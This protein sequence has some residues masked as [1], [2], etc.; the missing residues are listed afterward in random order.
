MNKLILNTGVQDFIKENLNTDI[1][2]VL[3]KKLLFN[4]IAQKELAQQLESRKR[5]QEKLPTWFN[6]DG[7][8]YP[9]K[10]HLEQT[11]SEIT[12]HYKSRLVNGNTLLDLT[13]GLGVDSYF[14]SKKM[15]WVTHCEMNA[16][17]SE[18][19]IYNFKVL[20][21]E[22]IEGVTE[23]G[24]DYLAEKPREWDWIFI[25]PS[26]RN[27]EKGK[28]FRL[29][30]CLPNVP[31][32]LPLI[33]QKTKNVLIKTSPLL[34]IAQGISELQ[35]VKE[36][37]AVA[38]KNE[39]KELLF[40]LEKDFS[41]EIEI[42]TIDLKKDKEIQFDFRM[43][44]ENQVTV[45]LGPPENFLYEPNAAILKSGG[46]KSIGAHY[47]L[48]KLHPHSHL[49][50]SET[51]VDFPGRRFE[52]LEVLPYSKHALKRMSIQKANITTRNFPLSVAE[53][54]KKHKITDGGELY[55]FFTKSINDNLMAIITRKCD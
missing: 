35:F 45:L 2:S 22:N 42:K 11:S 16:E 27:N 3:L 5:A 49:Y 12:A 52:I 10:L 38:V 55:L 15:D 26:R 47:G 24:L 29:E 43:I 25:D 17:L 48:K 19:A 9:K 51:L 18:I 21:C 8:F 6:S 33:F 41:G 1:V 53:L 39:V 13:G 32:L 54:R 14:F 50:T 31:R 28:V 23:N 7:I 4:G 44:G 36:V 20:G 40:V 34:D 46:F 30:D 37:H